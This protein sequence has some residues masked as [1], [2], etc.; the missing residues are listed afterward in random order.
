MPRQNDSDTNLLSM[1][2]FICCMI[3][4]FLLLRRIFLIFGTNR[5]YPPPSSD[6]FHDDFWR[7]S[8]LTRAFLIMHYF[9]CLSLEKTLSPAR[10]EFRLFRFSSA[11][12]TISFV[13]LLVTCIKHAHTWFI[14]VFFFVEL[15]RSPTKDSKT[16][17]AYIYTRGFLLVTAINLINGKAKEISNDIC[18]RWG[19]LRSRSWFPFFF[20]M[21]SRRTESLL[22]DI[23]RKRSIEEYRTQDH[24]AIDF[25]DT[26]V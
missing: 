9:N 8:S 2:I 6:P 26:V 22:I 19:N 5:S 21:S 12:V 18:R 16:F 7:H 24:D 14:S 23:F 15:E 4:S 20:T 1:F 17:S 11:Y 25:N 3:L 13:F 10:N